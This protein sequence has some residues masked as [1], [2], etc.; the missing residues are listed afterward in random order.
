MHNPMASI[1][2]AHCMQYLPDNPTVVE[3]GNQRY[4]AKE[5]EGEVEKITGKKVNAKSTSDFYGQLGFSKYTALDTNNGMGAAIYDLNHVPDVVPFWG[6]LVTNNGTGEHV[7]NQLAVFENAHVMCIT[8][9][10]MLH[11]LPFTPWLNHGFVNFNPI[12]FRDLARANN[13]KIIFHWIGNRWSVRAD[14]SGQDW[15]FQEKRPTMLMEL[16]ERLS[17]NGDLFNVVALQKQDDKPFQMPIQGKYN[18][19]ENITD[20]TLRQRYV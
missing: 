7:F 15:V 13:Y 16:V 4:G 18:T 9:G 8:G 14:V 20:D 3:F 12:L 17:G 2:V 5:V 19:K 6:D 11:I 10:I 1:A